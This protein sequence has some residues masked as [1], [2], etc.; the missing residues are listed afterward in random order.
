MSSEQSQSLPPQPTEHKPTEF[1]PTEQSSGESNTI[2][3][4]LD[5]TQGK[6][7]Y[8]CA[9]RF[10]RYTQ[11]K[12]DEAEGTCNCSTANGLVAE[13]TGLHQRPIRCDKNGNPL[14]GAKPIER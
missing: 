8:T 3:E 4:I 7:F 12:G 2:D 6:E 5:L 9:N 14:P 1:K 11:G 13:N 10:R